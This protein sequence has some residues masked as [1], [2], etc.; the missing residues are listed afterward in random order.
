MYVGNDYKPLS[1]E[2]DICNTKQHSTVVW[3][4]WSSLDH[5]ACRCFHCCLWDSGIY[6]TWDGV[7]LL[8]VFFC[9]KLI[10]IKGLPRSGGEKNYLEY[11]Y[12]RPKFMVTCTFA[13]FSLLKASHLS[14]VPR[15]H[16]DIHRT[17]HRQ[18]QHQMPSFS[19]NV[20]FITLFNTCDSGIYSSQ[21][22]FTPYLLSRRGSIHD[23]LPL[24]V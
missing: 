1:M 24:A 23:S 4:R 6:R 5:V 22:C 21:T 18:I 8:F 16:S 14:I 13:V 7:F 3:Q 9:S 2:Q 17:S 15:S 12:R 11:I 20:G 10:Y 19:V